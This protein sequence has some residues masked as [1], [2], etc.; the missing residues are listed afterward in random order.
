MSGEGGVWTGSRNLR[1]CLTERFAP[2]VLS[3]SDRVKVRIITGPET[4][5]PPGRR[6]VE[7]P[8]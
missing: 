6:E 8:P 5:P 1:S 4:G 7:F 3:K 2:L